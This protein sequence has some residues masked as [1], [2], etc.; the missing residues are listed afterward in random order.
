M[1]GRML[2]A[3]VGSAWPSRPSI[4]LTLESSTG[5]PYDELGTDFFTRRMD[6]ERETRRL[7]AKLEAL[8]HQVSLDPHPASRLTRAP[9]PHP[10]PAFPAR[11]RC[12]AP[13]GDHSAHGDERARLAVVVLVAVLLGLDAESIA[14]VIAWSAPRA[15]C[16]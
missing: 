13:A 1:V 3:D 4:R 6:P 8:G 9:S 12:R 16:G 5:R 2:P 7:I 14:L 10:E 15:S 11:V